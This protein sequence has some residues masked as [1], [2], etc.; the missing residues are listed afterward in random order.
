MEI[1]ILYED[2]DLLVV[3]KPAGLMVHPDGKSK[4][5]FLTDWIAKNY[6]KIKGVG[7]PSRTVKG[8]EIDRPGIVHRLD[9]ETSGALLIAKT[10]KAHEFLK[11]QFQDH[12]IKKT[13]KL[14]VHGSINEDEDV[15]NRPIGRSRSDFR[16][17]SAQRGIRGETREAITD[18]KV[19]ER[20][21]SGTK[22]GE[23][24]SYV[25]AMPRT[26][27]THQIRVH[28]KAI[29][30]PLVGD[31]LYA[32]NHPEALGFKRLALHSEKIA[33]TDLKGKKMEITAP[34]PEDFQNALKLFGH[35]DMAKKG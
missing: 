2:K 23:R 5:P 6:P 14:F 3:N 27:R 32:P 26:G 21:I 35:E 16:R 34:L 19:L 9:R 12:T 15:I 18:Y 8:D 10:Q 1:P 24:F 29:N 22:M 13:Y 17:W 33:F 20:S 4:G 11:K 25:E 31:T 28:F 30:Y 7:E